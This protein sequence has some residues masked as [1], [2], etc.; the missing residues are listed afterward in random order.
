MRINDTELHKPCVALR[1]FLGDARVD[2]LGRVAQELAH[3]LS[4]E[5]CMVLSEFMR[6][7][8]ES[9]TWGEVLGKRAGDE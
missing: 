4:A 1:T 7:Y 6:L 8:A 3:G 9:R 2:E 5:E